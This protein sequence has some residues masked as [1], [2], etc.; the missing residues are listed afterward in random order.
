[1]RVITT[2]I[3]FLIGITV[4][5]FAWNKYSVFREWTL[6]ILQQKNFKTLEV[7][8][9]AD[10]IMRSHKRELLKDGEHKFLDPTIIFHPYLLMEVKYN[11]PTNQTG[12]GLI[13]WSLVDGEMVINT[14]SWEKTHG[15]TDCIKSS[16]D[17]DNFKVINALSLNNGSMDRESLSRFLNVEDETL[18]RWLEICKRKNLIVQSGNIFRLHF[19]NPKIHVVPE[20]KINQGLVTKELKQAIKIAK[21]YRPSQIEN[22]AKAAFGLDFAIRKMTEVFLPVHSIKIQNPDGSQMTTYW[23]ALN[24]QQLSQNYYIE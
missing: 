3:F 10:N 16:A 12:E 18:D 7:R 17:R 11:R 8:Y 1:M 13:L 19:K 20:T 9:S 14:N 22:I 24:G 15:F 21:K 4:A 23:N 2:F 6:N 5:V